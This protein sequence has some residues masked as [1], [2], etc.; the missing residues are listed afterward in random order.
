MTCLLLL[1]LKLASFLSLSCK[2]AQSWQAFYRWYLALNSLSRLMEIN[3]GRITLLVKKNR[4]KRLF[5]FFDYLE[6]CISLS[7]RETPVAWEYL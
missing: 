3:G 5:V 6:R 7:Y 2:V 4:T 1:I